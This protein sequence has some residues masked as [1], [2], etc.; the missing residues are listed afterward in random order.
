ML[1]TVVI[2]HDDAYIQGEMLDMQS[3]FDQAIYYTTGGDERWQSVMNGLDKIC[4][5]GV[6]MVIGCLSMMQQDHVCLMLIWI[7]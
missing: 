3:S 7:D 4:A 1:L 2:A 5:E 6:W